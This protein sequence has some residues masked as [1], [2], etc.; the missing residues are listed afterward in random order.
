MQEDHAHAT[1]MKEMAEEKARIFR[2][3]TERVSAL[4]EVARDWKRKKERENRMKNEERELEGE[5]ETILSFKGISPNVEVEDKP[6][7]TENSIG[8]KQL[9]AFQAAGEEKKPREMNKSGVRF[10]ARKIIAREWGRILGRRRRDPRE[11]VLEH[12]AEEYKKR[13]DEE[14][15]KLEEER[16]RLEAQAEQLIACQLNLRSL[17]G[18]RIDSDLFE[19][20][21]RDLGRVV[22]ANKADDNWIIQLEPWEEMRIR[23]IERNGGLP[24]EVYEMKVN[25][26][27]EV[28]DYRHLPVPEENEEKED[29]SSEVLTKEEE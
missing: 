27:L 10:M 7:E 25:K 15:S 13:R 19:E 29:L 3:K 11:N 18:K 16:K 28:L 23:N 12:E 1:A 22:E 6:K 21:L 8:W 24:I 17:R 9:D 14:K 5:K 2:K 26:K 4:E 20:A